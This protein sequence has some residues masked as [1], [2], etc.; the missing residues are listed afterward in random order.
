MKIALVCP[1]DFTYPG[2]VVNHITALEREFTRM[3]HDVRIIAPASRKVTAFGDQFIGIG[4]AFPYPSSGSV[5][6]ITFS[7]WLDSH[8]KSVLER[9][10]FDI[11]HLHEPFCP[12]LCTAV[13]H[14][15]RTTNIG[16][17][18]AVDS[19]GYSQWKPFTATI[20]KRLY[21][22]LAGK[23][24][25][26]EP[27]REFTGRHFPGEYTVIPNGVDL[28]HFNAQVPPLEQYNDGRVNI[29]FVGRL[30]KR[31]GLDHLLDAYAGIMPSIP[32]SRLIVV[33]PGT[34]WSRR[35]EKQLLDGVSFTGMVPFSE[36]P[37]Y[38]STADIVC[39]PAT[40]RESFGMVLLEA[41]A[42]GKPVIASN[43]PGYASVLTHGI[44]GLLVPPADSRG[45]AEA[46]KYL[47]S[48]HHLRQEMGLRGRT[49]ASRYGWPEIARRLIDY[50][51]LVL[52]Q[53]QAKL[54]AKPG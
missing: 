18:H 15:S 44:E 37:R 23:I 50:Y 22:K 41:M 2:G 14:M 1:Y 32:Y 24:C 13:L 31:K 49:K 10:Q 26:S 35:Y 39:F 21:P 43:I 17:F 29:V 40:G 48:D 52:S 34:R 54:A 36:L 12:T 45:L 25:V 53:N 46:L 7:I 38:Y 5:A 33:G 27:A 11:I 47:I 30:E 28:E 19:R 16:T 4:R 20:L 6:R 9:E 51:N 8:V 42:V 3:G